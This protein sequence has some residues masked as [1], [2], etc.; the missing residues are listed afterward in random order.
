MADPD[1]GYLL[2]PA[3]GRG[4]GMG[5]LVRCVR[6]AHELGRGC[7]FHP[8]WLDDA[9]RA[10]LSDLL[11][12]IASGPRP[13]IIDPGVERGRWGIV[14][15]DKRRTTRAELE[16]L[17]RFG[18]VVC[19]DE[20]GEA[21]RSAAY[22]LDAV[23][24]IPGGETANSASLSY[25]GLRVGTDR[26]RRGRARPA[27]ALVS[28]GGEDTPDL[29]GAFLRAAIGGGLLAARNITVVVGPLFGNHTWPEG[30][31]QVHG[32]RRLQP[33]FVGRDLLV[34]H[35]G[36]SALEALAAGLPVVLLNP[37]SYHRVLA[38]STGI[39]EIGVR[40]IRLRKLIR[41]PVPVV[42]RWNRTFLLRPLRAP[43]P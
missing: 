12:R 2:V 8:G 1:R 3:G 19:L 13:R 16:A 6:L 42:R 5:H 4:E 22:L 31:N 15:V 23:P 43:E 27:R 11:E 21:R 29:T 34:T 14:L 7:A 18:T 38:R 33:L 24:R 28:F 25:L 40:R 41:M 9:A 20:G 36:I 30:V 32:V 17:E 26:S 39:P 35:F 10:S 37:T